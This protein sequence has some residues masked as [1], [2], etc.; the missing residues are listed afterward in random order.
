MELQILRQR[1]S[2]TLDHGLNVGVGRHR[3]IVTENSRLL[4]ID[5]ELA[6]RP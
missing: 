4:L 3:D 5:M 6:Y 2:Q 1:V